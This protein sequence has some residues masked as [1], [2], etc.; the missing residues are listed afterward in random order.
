[1][2]PRTTR[3]LALVELVPEA[4]SVENLQAA[5]TFHHVLHRLGYL[6]RAIA[7]GARIFERHRD[8][9]TAHQLATELAVLGHSDPA[10]AWLRT[11]LADP[12]EHDRLSDSGL[13]ALR[14]R[15]DWASAIG[16]PPPR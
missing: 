10:M 12:A 6:Q 16:M 15:P 11:A 7:Y 13:D 5:R 9:F 2:M 1:M 14:S 3:C 4:A 8:S